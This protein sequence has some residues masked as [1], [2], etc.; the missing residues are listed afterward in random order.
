VSGVLEMPLAFTVVIPTYNRAHVLGRAIQSVLNQVWAGVEIVVVDDASTDPAV[1]TVVSQYRGVRYVAQERNMGPSAA[2]NRGLMEARHPWVIMLD[3][4]DEL[5]PSA[6]E[7]ISA[8][9]ER[10]PHYERYSVFQ[11][12][13]ANGKLRADSLVVRLQDYLNGGIKGDFVPVIQRR[14]FLERGYSYPDNRAGAEHLLWWTVAMTEGIPSF[15]E[16]VA[17]LNTDAPNRLT[18]V[19]AQVRNAQALALAQDETIARFGELLKAQAPAL[20]LRKCLGSATYWLLAGEREKARQRLRAER[21]A[22]YL[23]AAAGLYVLTFL[24]SSFATRLYKRLR[25]QK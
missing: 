14:I 20:Y 13:H 18:S 16:K 24:P 6:L 11:F 8:T 1:R 21:W 5:L 15:A 12:A 7:R 9:I 2:R 3:D 19:D 10:Y 17:K 4:D 23:P 22:G 25:R